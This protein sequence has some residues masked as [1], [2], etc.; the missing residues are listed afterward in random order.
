MT[1]RQ[2]LPESI[3]LSREEARTVY[4]GIVAAIDELPSG[5]ARAWC[6]EAQRVLVV[7]LLPDLPDL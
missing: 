7:K 5:E 4:L 6:E 1:D 2:S 3:E